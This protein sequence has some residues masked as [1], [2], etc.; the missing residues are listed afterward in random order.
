MNAT[1]QDLLKRRLLY[2]LHLGFVE[3]R[4]LALGAGN[5][6]IADLADALEILPQYI[7][8]DWS[9]DD[10]AMIRFV[11]KNYQDKHPSTFDYPARLDQYDPPE[12]Y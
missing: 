8:K 11:L 9:E 7:E 10:L 1:D 3:V 5:E 6:R 12:R 4:N 2:I